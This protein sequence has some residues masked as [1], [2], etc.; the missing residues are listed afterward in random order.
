MDDLTLT[1]SNVA[2]QGNGCI[3]LIPLGELPARFCEMLAQ[4]VELVEEFRPSKVLDAVLLLPGANAEQAIAEMARTGNLLAALLDLTGGNHPRADHA[5]QA[6]L[7]SLAR[8]LE[9]AVRIRTAIGRLAPIPANDDAGGLTAIALALT[10]DRS[11]EPR[12]NSTVADFVSYPLLAGLKDQRSLLEGLAGAKL[13]KRRFFERL[14]V[15]G[16]CQS[17]RAVPREVC[18]QCGSSDLSEDTLVHHYKCGYQAPKSTFVTNDRLACPK[19]DRQLRH[20]GV[21]YDTPGSVRVCQTCSAISAEPEIS[22]LC[23][24]CSAM[25]RGIDVRT[26]DWFCY[27]LTPLAET[28][29]AEGR[30]PGTGVEGLLNGLPGWRTP[31]D[32][33]L[34][35]DLAHR[36]G[37][38]YGRPYAVLEIDLSA[39]ESGVA[40]LG[41][42]GIAKLQR[43][44]V[45]VISE[46]VRDSDFL[47]TFDR[48][49]LLFLPETSHE[50]CHFLLNRLRARV[51]KTL[52]DRAQISAR[53]VP[54]AEIPILVQQI[55]K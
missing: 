9:M 52:G 8:G 27:D 34:M 2:S 10:R 28:A 31:R 19:C 39:T 6:T 25:T 54:E 23:I 49:I 32:L 53:I 1:D 16:E 45:D 38:R 14:H 15:C 7:D 47:A 22:F 12:L 3:R 44:M 51:T 40:A 48:K 43:V 17:A 11:I 35:I 30:L 20:Y 18:P 24:D 41:E 55:S 13:L 26:R 4:E 50:N 5:G 37:V 33:A 42:V 29:A 46:T 36:I 21:D